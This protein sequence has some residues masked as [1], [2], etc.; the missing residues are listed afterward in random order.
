MIPKHMTLWLRQAKSS[1]G[2]MNPFFSGITTHSL[3]K[4]YVPQDHSVGLDK[5]F[6]EQPWWGNHMTLGWGY[7]EACLSSISYLLSRKEKV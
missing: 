1:V 3:T 5:L 7:V 6:T 2:S 4:D